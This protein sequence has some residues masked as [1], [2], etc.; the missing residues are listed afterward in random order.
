MI[1][2]PSMLWLLA[3]TPVET[4]VGHQVSYGHRDIPILGRADTRSDTFVVATVWR[5][6]DHLWVEQRACAVTFAEVWGVTVS[7]PQTALAALPSAPIQ[8]HLDAHGG[9]HAAP[10]FVGWGGEDVE[11]DGRPGLTIRVDAP[12]CSGDVYVASGTTSEA[13]GKV[14][15]AGMVG[16]MTV[17]VQQE[18]L[19]ASSRCLTWGERNTDEQQTAVFAFRRVPAGTTCADLARR[20]WPVRAD[21]PKEK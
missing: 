19:G 6:G 15:E 5:T 3:Q 13:T 18:T 20:P 4:W 9:A 2:W 16:R 11:G 7:M 21:A 10:W 12:L 8:F 1:L 17:R 14:T